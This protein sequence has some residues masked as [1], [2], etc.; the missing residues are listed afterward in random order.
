VVVDMY[1]H[2]S[3]YIILG[4]L[5]MRIVNMIKTQYGG[6]SSKVQAKGFFFLLK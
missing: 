4:C 3:E 6:A 5:G 1:V 2:K